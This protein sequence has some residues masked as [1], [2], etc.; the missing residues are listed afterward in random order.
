VTYVN[1]SE[2]PSG[3]ARTVTILANDGAASSVIATDTINVTP[4]NDAPVTTAGGTLNY[5]ENQVATAIDATV[6]VSDVDNTNLSSATVQLTTNYVNGQD[7]LGFTTQNGI[8][9][10]FNAATG[11]MTLSGSSS[12]AN[13]Q[14]ALRSVTYFDNSDNPSG[15][16]RTVVYTANDGAVNSNSST[17]TIHVTPVNDAPV[18]TATGTLAYTENQVATAIAP[19]LTVT[20]ADTGTL[21]TASVQISANYV[22]GEDVLAFSTQNGITGSF[23]A[24][25][26]TMTLTGSASVANYQTAMESV[27]YVNTSENPSTA[28]RT[29]TFNADDGQAANHLSA[30]SNHTITVASVDDTPVN[31]GVPGQFTVMS[32]FT[33]AITGLSI[34]D[35]DAGSGNDITTTLTS[36]DGGFVTVGAVGGGAA[37]TGNS[38]GTV[39]LTGTIGQIN[40]SLGGSVVYTAADNVTTSSQTTLTIATNDQGHTGTGGPITDTD[41]VAVGVTPQVWFINQDQSSLDSNAARGSQTNPFSDVTEFNAASLTA[42]GP[43]NNDYIYV[44]AG[45]YTGPGINLKDGQTLLGDDQA[46][47]LADPFGGPAIVIETSSGARPTIN[48]TTAGDQGIDLGVGNTIHGINITTAA[49]TTG[50]DDGN[51]AVG[52][53]TVDQM[54]ISGAGQAVDIDQG[55]ALTV[56]LESLSSSGGAEGIQLAGTASSGT[57]LLSGTFSVGGTGAISGSTTAGIM[58]GNGGATASAGGTVAVTYNGTVTTTGAAHAVDI[59]DRAAGAGNIGLG[60]TISHASG[61]GS[62]IFLDQNAAGTIAFSGASSVLNSGTTDAV[63]ITNNGAT[64]NFTGDGLNID[65]TSGAGFLASG[66]GTVNVTGS[67][68]S[69]ATGT[70]TALSISGT[71]IGASNVT[72]HDISAN[73]GANGIFLNTT[74]S[75]G[76][77]H[78]TGTGTNV[79]ATGGGVIQNMSGAD[80]S[81]SGTGIYL[82]ST[83]DV[84]LNG[85]QLNG[86]T[87]FGVRGLSVDGVS[88]TNTTIS[89]TSGNNDAFDEAAVAFG[90]SAGTTGI[91]GTGTFTNLDVRGGFE[92]NL[93]FFQTSGTSNLTFTNLSSHD[94]KTDSP[95]FGADG[96][97]LETQSSANSTVLIQNSSFSNNFTQGVQGTALDTSTLNMTV[98]ASTFT[99][100]NEG[101]VLADSGSG[102][103]TATVGGNTAADGNTLTGQ[104]GLGIFVGTAGTL[105]TSAS[106]IGAIRHNTVTQPAAS[107]NHGIVS[108]IGGPSTGA[109]PATVLDI[110]F[111]TVSTTGTI[112]AIRVDTPDTGSSPT[113]DA[114]VNNNVVSTTG[115]GANAIQLQ[116]RRG[117]GDFHVQGNSGTA[118]QADVLFVRQTNADGAGNPA[119]LDLERGVSASNDPTQ[120]LKDNNPLISGTAPQ[121]ITV[122]GT[123]N[124]VNNGA[125]TT[126]P[127]LASAGG[128]V[129]ALNS[130]GEFHLT[131][132]ELD[133][134]VQAAIARW[135]AAGLSADQLSLLHNLSF[136]VADMDGA[137]L[138]AATAGSIKIDSDGGSYGWFVDPTPQGDTEFGHAASA[139]HL[140]TDPTEAPAGHMDLLTTVMH[141][142][143]HQLGLDDTYNAG[144][145]DDLMF[146]FLTTGER[147]LPDS[148]EVAQANADAGAMQAE[149][150]LPVSARAAAGTPVIVGTAGNDTIDAGHGGNILFGGAG[151]DT[152][153]FGPSIQLNA[154]TPAQITHV[155]DYSAAQGDTFDF[156]ALTSAFH[157]SSVSDAL[158]VRAVE[159]ASGKFA[160]LQVDH[161][162]PM[163]LPSAP[164]WVSVAQIDGAHA[165][166]AVN[167]VIDNHSVHLA[168]IHVDLLV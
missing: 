22:N 142:M 5:T 26:G 129:S 98:R 141:E 97:L 115:L 48:V 89:G 21:T 31:N 8:T 60:G 18:V 145:R 34:S 43:G 161:I 46:L 44:K 165:G 106:L 23:D 150:A 108:L 7:I 27:T 37:I 104:T 73:G 90:T 70:G 111:N 85:L 24:L 61:N 17:S 146:G 92:N 151:A 62:S 72:F 96:F 107:N 168:Q 102:D 15:L 157:N 133:A 167:V 33:H 58:V 112:N 126:V 137:A 13:Y 158:V 84:Q 56:S 14:T 10:V 153:V 50:L 79:G 1:T 28:A 143:G 166:D 9:G 86:F 32:G 156:S 12:V 52:A 119:T 87:N 117:N 36:A 45:T 80:G 139:T 116:A 39:T 67:S 103:L 149:T 29:V 124:V 77:F 3:L 100:N 63:H 11:T 135:G 51:N 81:T 140:T 49:G 128:V 57:G 38:T 68:N 105:T 53:L 114:T 125:V 132:L 101:V 130:G 4:V 94:T 78:L 40:A 138:G 152:F 99:G 136:S 71:T 122:L 109:T 54:Q 82:N 6:T 144:D 162:D 118:T 164:N 65:A 120:V 66:G 47:S 42:T 159:D 83:H 88:L 155:A 30:G 35:V 20:D 74:G 110:S 16:D 160:T 121:G 95:S 19:A 75:T 55:G 59:Q 64:V 69:I 91:T 163:G 76:G 41:V 113:F 131:Q 25:S 93:Q 127:L 147:R 123:V 154:P 148:T 2:N 134:V